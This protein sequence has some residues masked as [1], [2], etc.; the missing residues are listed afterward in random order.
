MIERADV[1]HDAE[2]EDREAL[3][4]AA[5]EQV[6]EAED[7]VRAPPRRS[8]CSAC[9]VDPGRRDRDADAIDR[10]HPEREQQAASELGTREA[11]WKPFE[12]AQTFLTGSRRRLDVPPAAR[13]PR[14]RLAE[15]LSTLTVSVLRRARRCRG[16]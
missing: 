4:R 8:G 15:A 3:E 12:H 7:V 11:F 10:E 16:A 5:R 1:R 2:R 14:A 13:S 9:A 6:D